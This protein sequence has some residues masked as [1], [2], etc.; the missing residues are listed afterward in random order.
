MKNNNNIGKFWQIPASFHC[1]TVELKKKKKH[2][3]HKEEGQGGPDAIDCCL[4]IE[5]ERLL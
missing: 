4:V 1:S 2:T 5:V 3:Q